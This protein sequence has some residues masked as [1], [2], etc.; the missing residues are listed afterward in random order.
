LV[1]ILLLTGDFII[2]TADPSIATQRHHQVLRL[3]GLLGSCVRLAL[4]P[5]VLMLVIQERHD[6]LMVGLTHLVVASLGR[7]HV[8]C[9]GL[10]RLVV[11][12]DTA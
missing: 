6:L 5:I 9:G 8:G 7:G 10:A 11:R 12:C 1:I 4:N 2:V 3:L